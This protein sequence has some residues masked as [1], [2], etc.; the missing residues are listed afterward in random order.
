MVVAPKPWPCDI[1]RME[2]TEHRLERLLARVR[3]LPD[4]RQRAIVEA[5]EEI[6]T[7]P[8]RLSAEEL[9]VLRP[10]VAEARS[11]ANL[12]DA[13]TDESLNLPWG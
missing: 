8:Y 11:G 4:E 6:A 3:S 10:A 13:D 12:T 2:T 5:I 7:E 9:E 1:F